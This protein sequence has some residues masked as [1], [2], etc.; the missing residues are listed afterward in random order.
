MFSSINRIC[1]IYNYAD[2]NSISYNDKNPQNIKH[3]LEQAVNEALT[4]FKINHLQENP[5]KFKAIYFS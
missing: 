5:S 1:K 2:D 4:W 3:T